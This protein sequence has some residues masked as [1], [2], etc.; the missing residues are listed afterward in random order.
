MKHIYIV[1]IILI[2]VLA[3]N[4]KKI[5]NFVSTIYPN[6]IIDENMEVT[7]TNTLKSIIEYINKKDNKEYKIT[8]VEDYWT[9]QK[10]DYDFLYLNLMISEVNLHFQRRVRVISKLKF[11][12]LL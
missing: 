8:E 2:L 12:F 1:L 6:S 11:V 3:I 4:Y 9:V 5:E 10:D 7:L